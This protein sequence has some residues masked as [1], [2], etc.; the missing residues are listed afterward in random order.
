MLTRVKIQ[1]KMNKPRV[2]QN[3]ERTLMKAQ[4]ILRKRPIE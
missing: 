2:K 1:K 3:S 4:A